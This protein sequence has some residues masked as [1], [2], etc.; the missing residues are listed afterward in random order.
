MKTL[1]QTDQL[2]KSKAKY[3]GM[4]HCF[5]DQIKGGNIGTFYK[6]IGVALYRAAAVNAGGFFAFEG[7]L[8]YMGKP[9]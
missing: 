2:D 4:I 3:S 9:E 5:K 1:L 7:A 8:R 6:G